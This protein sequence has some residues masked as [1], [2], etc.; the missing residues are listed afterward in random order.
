MVSESVMRA[1]APSMLR[2]FWVALLLFGGILA[3]DAS[4]FPD[5]GSLARWMG[6]YYQSPEPQRLAEAVRQF[7]GD[8]AQLAHPER[9]DSPAHFFAVVAWSNPDARRNLSTLGDTVPAGPG[10]DFIARVLNG[11]GRLEFARARDPNDLDIAWAHFSATGSIESVRIVLAAIDFREEDVDLALPV[12]RAVKVS[13]R[14]EGARLMRGASAWSLSKHAQAHPRVRE[15][16]ER[17][18]AEAMTEK[19]REQLR[20]ILDGKISLK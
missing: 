20:R 7:I 6:H 2:P 12:W 19:R 8:P 13:D 1:R 4:A 9:L 17:E 16:L 10:K 5:A 14:A 3:A 15:L 18:L 11:S